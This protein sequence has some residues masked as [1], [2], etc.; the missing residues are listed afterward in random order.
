MSRPSSLCNSVLY[1]CTVERIMWSLFPCWS[2]FIICVQRFCPLS[3]RFYHHHHHHHHRHR[4]K[5]FV[6]VLSTGR[7][8]PPI[9]CFYSYECW[10][11]IGGVGSIC[12]YWP[13]ALPDAK[14]STSSVQVLSISGLSLNCW[15]CHLQSKV[16][17]HVHRPRP[18]RSQQ[19][20][21]V[22]GSTEDCA[23]SEIILAATG[24]VLQH[25]RSLRPATAK[26]NR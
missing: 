15:I 5:S 1:C 18:P 23:V 9:E 24:S 21:S 25:G 19:G 3:S 4:F 17:V 20:L 8:V 6:S 22:F 10:N 13:D 11:S 26:P 12:F 7:T 16:A 2:S 14:S